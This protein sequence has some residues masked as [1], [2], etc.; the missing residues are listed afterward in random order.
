[1][2]SQLKN[3]H[4]PVRDLAKGQ[5]FFKRLGFKAAVGWKKTDVLPQ[6]VIDK[7]PILDMWEDEMVQLLDENDMGIELICFDDS[8]KYDEGYAK[9]RTGINIY[10]DN[11][12]EALAA[13][14]DLP[15]VRIVA[16]PVDAPAE[17]IEALAPMAREKI[18]MA[19]TAERIAFI[20]VDLGRLDGEE[21][22]V[23]LEE[24]H[25]SK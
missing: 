12:D 19:V 23:L 6:E 10:V 4:I 5:E 22:T 25:F 1:M 24:L 20:N 13:I 9:G 14:R 17:L 7:L 3:V 15:G 16:G 11:L 21:Q 18:G 2:G 8:F